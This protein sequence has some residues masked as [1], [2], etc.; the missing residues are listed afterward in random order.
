M[1]Y[2]LKSRKSPSLWAAGSSW[3]HLSCSSPILQLVSNSTLFSQGVTTQ[4]VVLSEGPDF[5]GRPSSSQLATGGV[6][7]FSMQF[8][9]QSGHEHTGIIS[10][11]EYS[12]FNATTGESIT[13]VYD[14]SD[15]SNFAP[16]NSLKA[17]APAVSDLRH[18]LKPD[19]ACPPVFLDK[20]AA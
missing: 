4:A 17:N 13:I 3:L 9:D 6:E 16:L 19:H 10:Q 20:K 12:G 1:M 7:S 15:P 5:C 11:C 8:S 2:R 18:S 14:P